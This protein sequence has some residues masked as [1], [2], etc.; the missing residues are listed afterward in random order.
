MRFFLRRCA[1]MSG[2]VPFTPD[3]AEAGK[4]PSSMAEDFA[5]A[6]KTGTQQNHIRKRKARGMR[7]CTV[8]SVRSLCGS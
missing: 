3:D 8:I 6:N 7:Q 1:Q 2:I 5:A 4:R